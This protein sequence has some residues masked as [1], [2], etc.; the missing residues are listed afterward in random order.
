[1][2]PITR[3]PVSNSENISQAPALFPI[4]ISNDLSFLISAVKEA[5]TNLRTLKP[6][7]IQTGD[8]MAILDITKAFM[9]TVSSSQFVLESDPS[10]AYLALNAAW[11]IIKNLEDHFM[12]RPSQLEQQHKHQLVRFQGGG[13]SE[14]M[15]LSPTDLNGVAILEDPL[16]TGIPNSLQDTI[17]SSNN[18]IAPFDQGRNEKEKKATKYCIVSGIDQQ[19]SERVVL[20]SGQKLMVDIKAKP[21]KA[22]TKEQF[23][24]LEDLPP[25]TQNN[26]EILMKR[27]KILMDRTQASQTKIQVRAILT[28]CNINMV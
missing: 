28:L 15:I 21:T 24:R 12:H 6:L 11:T 1:V 23:S 9:N 8:S 26:P 22:K 20:A 13:M 19:L 3:Q 4:D 17:L 27:L 18:T 16:V 5:Q 2:D 14:H 10:N 25:P 7:V